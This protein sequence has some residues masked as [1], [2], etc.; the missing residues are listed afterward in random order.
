MS[1]GKCTDMQPDSWAA[2][3]ATSGARR[4][5]K[6]HRLARLMAE[7]LQRMNERRAVMARYSAPATHSQRSSH[8]HS[9]LARRAT[10]LSGD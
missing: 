2:G 4:T 1:S 8:V 10:R 6:C 9:M 5:G 3:P 7:Q